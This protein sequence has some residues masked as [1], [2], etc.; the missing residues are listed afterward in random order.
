MYIYV[1]KIQPQ[2]K[3]W[4]EGGGAVTVSGPFKK[5]GRSLNIIVGCF[6]RKLILGFVSISPS[7][8]PHL[9]GENLKR[10]KKE[11]NGKR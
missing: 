2:P 5:K 3:T 8:L 7:A 4:R 6:I 11:G 1:K 9:R 10:G